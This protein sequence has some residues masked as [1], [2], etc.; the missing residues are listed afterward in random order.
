MKKF[1]IILAFFLSALSGFAQNA[2]NID[3][4]N[5]RFTIEEGTGANWHTYRTKRLWGNVR[6]VTDPNE[7][8]DLRVHIVNH[9]GLRILNISVVEKA[10]DWDQ[11][12]WVYRKGEE[13]FTI[14]IV[15]DYWDISVRIVSGYNPKTKQTVKKK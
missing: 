11:W 7:H 15:E 8:A 6:I 5:R 4:Y 12:H 3:I 10:V 1:A 2:E 9:E 13:D 14:R